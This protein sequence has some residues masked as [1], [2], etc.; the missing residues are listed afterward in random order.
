M[1]YDR[2]RTF[3]IFN[4][5]HNTTTTIIYRSA[6][7][8]MNC[9]SFSF[10]LLVFYFYR[11]F[12][13]WAPPHSIKLVL[14]LLMIWLYANHTSNKRALL[15]ASTGQSITDLLHPSKASRRCHYPTNPYP[16]TSRHPSTHWNYKATKRT[17]WSNLK[18]LSSCIHV[19]LNPHGVGPYGSH[20]RFKQSGKNWRLF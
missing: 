20:W 17:S 11:I 8:Y 4:I 9:I 6:C 14:Y 7:V 5:M 13:W 2:T 16:V 15:V 3:A 18:R 19:L 10:P 12:Q 1:L